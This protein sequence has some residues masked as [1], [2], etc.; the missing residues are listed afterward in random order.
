MYERQIAQF[1]H[2]DPIQFARG[3]MWGA[4]NDIPD[5]LES[6]SIP[7]SPVSLDPGDLPSN[8]NGKQGT[9]ETS[10]E[11]ALDEESV[12]SKKDDDATEA[13]QNAETQQSLDAHSSGSQEGDEEL[14]EDDGEW[15]NVE[16]EDHEETDAVM[17]MLG[18]YQVTRGQ[19]DDQKDDATPMLGNY[20]VTRGPEPTDESSEKS[21]KK[22]T[23]DTQKANRSLTPARG[24]SGV[25]NDE[26]ES[27]AAGDWTDVE[28]GTDEEVEDD[29]DSPQENGGMP[30]LGKYKVTRGDTPSDGDHETPEAGKESGHDSSPSMA[31][32]TSAQET[33]RQDVTTPVRVSQF[34]GP[35]TSDS[36]TTNQPGDAAVSRAPPHGPSNPTNLPKPQ[37]PPGAPTGPRAHTSRNPSPESSDNDL[38]TS[39]QL[40]NLDTTPRVRLPAPRQ[41]GIDNPDPTPRVRLPQQ[42][43]QNQT[44]PALVTPSTRTS[45]QGEL[46]N[47][48]NSQ[49]AIFRQ[50]PRTLEPQ[51]KPANQGSPLRDV[52][53]ASPFRKDT[54]GMQDGNR[55]PPTGPAAGIPHWSP[56]GNARGGRGG[57]GARQL[58]RAPARTVPADT[59]RTG[60]TTPALGSGNQSPD[61]SVGGGDEGGRSQQ[62]PVGGSIPRGPA[63]ATATNN[64]PTRRSGRERGPG[65]A[66]S[67]FQ[68]FQERMAMEKRS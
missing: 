42:P 18:R 28:D 62:G 54:G 30:T 41:C 23:L 10:I 52:S 5:P 1:L 51:S 17:P 37:P 24:E 53:V 36:D 2:P 47:S 3:S 59:P 66:N 61:F 11:G 34:A 7:S 67:S 27:E 45:T 20:K 6:M 25:S 21:Q 9:S 49:P 12:T 43:M 13:S 48:T 33:S 50:A 63:A 39:V 35:S 4:L 65:T 40:N 58:H 32:G 31:C 29:E 8:G 22:P 56:R 19:K 64:T 44:Q 26:E 46:D 57:R 16:D 38:Q 68:R 15:S 14:D 55:A 60:P